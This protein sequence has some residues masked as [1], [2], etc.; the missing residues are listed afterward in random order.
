MKATH[1]PLAVHGDVDAEGQIVDRARM[2]RLRRAIG[3]FLAKDVDAESQLALTLLA[4][5]RQARTA[6]R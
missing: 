6:A 5:A 3:P 2:D 4:L 1:Q